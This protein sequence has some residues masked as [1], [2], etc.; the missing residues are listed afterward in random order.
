MDFGFTT[1]AYVVAAILFILSL[2]GLS[3]QESAKR[4]VWYGI[5]GMALAVA[6]TLIGPGAGFWLLSLILIAGGGAIGYQLA[7]KV[8]MTQ[9]PELVAA[10]HSLVGLAAVFVGYNAHIELGN[11]LA[12]DDTARKAT[13]GFA[14]LLA[15]KDSVEIAILR[16]ELFLGVFIGAITFT[17]S[18][19]AYGKLAGRVDTSATKLP[20]GHILNAAAAGLSLLCLVWYFNTGGFLPLFIMTLA[21][22]FIGYHLIMG[23]GGA[24]MPVVVSM[25]NSYSGWAAAAIG[26]SLGNDL[27]IVVG[28]LVGSS[29]AILS[30]I[31]CK[32][33]NR[34]FVSVILGGF[35]GT[36]GPQMEVEGEQVAIDTD[37]VATLLN[38]ADSVI[39]IPGYGMAVAQAQQAVSEL[40]K[41]LRAKGKNVRFAIHPVA[42]RLPGH[43]N[44]LLAE[45]KVP[46]DIVMEMDE[47]NDDFPSTDVAIVIGSNDIVNP[48]AQDDPNSPIAGMPVLECWKAKNVIV[49]KRGQGTGY[50]GI[51]N[52]LFF[53][54]NTRM[55]YGDAK[56]SLDK[57][58][59]LID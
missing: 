38:E 55:L 27:L 26:F 22:L 14:A 52:P 21:A 24:D 15:K 28:A 4:A 57:L 43:M 20:G 50:S 51:E 2:G 11:V 49:S 16:V 6:A 41:K 31:M 44:V 13:E 33:M 1:A 54:D 59:P 42:G 46:Y 36:S 48:A 37:G 19:I 17:G 10:M 18:V 5:V 7:T 32:A 25:L 58:L 9:M 39:I 12:M 35:G 56:A 23:I 45:A 30:Y 40:V 29:G 53:K 34:S 3:G 8:Q 47:I